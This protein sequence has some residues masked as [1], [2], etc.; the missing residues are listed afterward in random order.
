MSVPQDMAEKECITISC[1]ITSCFLISEA[2]L[3]PVEQLKATE[4]ER[5]VVAKLRRM[6]RDG[7]R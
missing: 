7:G 2:P 6:L 5:T 1:P 3:K 4:W